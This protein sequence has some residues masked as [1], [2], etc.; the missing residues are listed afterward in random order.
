MTEPLI[1]PSGI[2]IVA[3]ISDGWRTRFVDDRL[4]LVHATE[5]PRIVPISS[6]VEGDILPR[7]TDEVMD[8]GAQISGY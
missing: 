2:T 3:T 7:E 6:I 5:Q 1:A 8:F 4:I